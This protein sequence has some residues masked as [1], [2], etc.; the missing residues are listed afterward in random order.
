MASPDD[1]QGMFDILTYQKGGAILRMLEQYLGADRFRDGIR[2]YLT[3]TSS[4][5]PRR[6]TSGT[7]SRRPPASRCAGSWT[8]GSGRAATRLLSVEPEDGG[9][10]I[11]QSRFLAD[12]SPDATVWDVP[13]RVRSLGGEEQ[14][15]LVTA[16]GATVEVPADAAVVVN[17]GASSFVRVRYDAELRERLV[18]RLTEVSPM[19]RYTLVD[20]LWAS[21]VAGAASAADFVGSPTP[22]ARRTTSPCGRC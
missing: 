5:T 15:V 16:D 4:G 19:E 22:S 3:R 17:A 9:V 10:S 6:T 14:S 7:R 20:D 2:R 12:G 8:R 21:V 13:L 18:A 1:A 11:T